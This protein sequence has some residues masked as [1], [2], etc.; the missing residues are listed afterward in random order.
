MRTVSR[1][2]ARSQI[3][4][5]ELCEQDGGHVLWRDASCRIV[6]IDEP[7]YSGFC[8]VIWGAHVKEMTDL[9]AEARAALMR[10]VFAVE[11]V[12]REVLRPHKVNLASL[13][14]MTPHL[15][16]HVIPRFENDPHFPN[17][18][19]GVRIRAPAPTDG[20]KLMAE[21]RRALG[22]YLG[23]SRSD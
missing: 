20:P 11:N 18:I 4:S 6:Y 15:H 16:W 9:P 2:A 3:M 17:P 23:A 1:T 21:L 7:G 22:Q 14:N 10:A 13:G 19:W 8:R 5:C 12:L